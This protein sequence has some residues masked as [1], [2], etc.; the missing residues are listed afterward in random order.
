M[1]CRRRRIFGGVRLGLRLL[2]GRISS[3]EWEP[4]SRRELTLLGAYFLFLVSV[5]DVLN[6]RLGVELL[7]LATAVGATFISRMLRPFLRDWWPFLV[8]LIMWN[9][10]G[11]IAGKSPFPVHLQPMLNLDSWI[12]FGHQPVQL[13][14]HA[15]YVPGHVGPLDVLTSIVYNLHLPE[16]YIVGY[17]LWRINRPVF[18]R[19]AASVLILLVLGFLTFVV[20]PAMPPWMSSLRFGRPAHVIN[21][22]NPVIHSHPLPFH[23]TPIFYLFH[24]TGDAVAAFPSEHAAFPLLEVL[25]FISLFGRRAW[26]LLLWPAA[27]LFSILY[28]GEHWLTDALAGYAY[29]A[30]VWF[31]VRYVTRWQAASTPA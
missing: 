1:H 11:A 28:L 10:S 27:V 23:G 25:A 15:F 8:G 16:P 30:L 29:A 20:F 4:A 17:I 12:A 6:V 31:T 19:Y 24:L 14:Q 2:T 9:L 18:F 26:P 7:T 13:L 3:S 5:T 21:G 22:F